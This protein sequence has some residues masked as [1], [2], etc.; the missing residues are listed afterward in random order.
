MINQQPYLHPQ[1][2]TILLMRDALSASS[3]T[4]SRV[5]LDG[6]MGHDI[7]EPYINSESM[8]TKSDK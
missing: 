8:W 4:T 7:C 2:P 1:S 6:P 3:L 5:L